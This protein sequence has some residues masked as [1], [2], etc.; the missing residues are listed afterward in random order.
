[1]HYH[2]IQNHLMRGFPGLLAEKG[3]EMVTQAKV[4]CNFQKNSHYGFQKYKNLW[5]KTALFKNT[6]CGDFQAY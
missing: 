5:Y 4:R 3:G 1:M 2:I 6:L